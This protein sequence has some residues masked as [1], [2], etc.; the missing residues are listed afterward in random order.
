MQRC[1]WA[2]GSDEL[3]RR[4]HDEEY[5]R[6]K[7]SDRELL[8][9]LCLE[10]FQAG[11]SWRTVLH[12]REAL[13]QQFYDFDIARVAAMTEADV[14]RLMQDERIIRCRRKIEAV[15][16]NARRQAALFCASGSFQAYVYGFESGE[17]LSKDLKR[18][19]YR[20]AGPVICE[21]FL[22]SVGAV[23]GH[24]KHCLLFGGMR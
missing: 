5:G 11:L 6:V 1:G 18:K 9:K 3:L 19:G 23:E 12:K 7:K 10:C 16:Q 14:E 24:E 13:R 2:N 15:I 20:F 4:Y 21:A 17:A 22:Q 8:E